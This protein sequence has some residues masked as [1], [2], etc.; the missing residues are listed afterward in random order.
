VGGGIDGVYN[1]LTGQRANYRDAFDGCTDQQ[2]SYTSHNRGLLARLWGEAKSWGKA[3]GSQHHVSAAFDTASG[4]LTSPTEKNH[5]VNA[6]TAYVKNHI[7]PTGKLIYLVGTSRGGCVMYNVARKLKA[8]P[9]Y[10]GTPILLQMNDPVCRPGD[11]EG[12]ASSYVTKS[13]PITTDSSYYSFGMNVDAHFSLKAKKSLRIY[14]IV[15]GAEVIDVSG[16]RSWVDESTPTGALN[17][18]KSWSEG[19]QT[20]VW[21]EQTWQYAHHQFFGRTCGDVANIDDPMAN[22]FHSAID[23]FWCSGSATFNPAN[24]TCCPTGQYWSAAT[25]S[26]QTAPTCTSNGYIQPGSDPSYCVECGDQYKKNAA[27][28]AC[29]RIC[30]SCT[31]F[32]GSYSS[33]TTCTREGLCSTSASPQ[34]VARVC[35][36]NL[37]CITGSVEGICGCP[38]AGTVLDIRTNSCIAQPCFDTNKFY[39]DGAQCVDTCKFIPHAP[40]DPALHYDCTLKNCVSGTTISKVFDPYSGQ[41]GT[42][43]VK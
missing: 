11:D 39:Y 32:T 20:G 7:P 26:C 5:I 13:N 36:S 42:Y 21:Y 43:A 4:Y 37:S 34:C 22:R 16:A 3:V 8:D 15:S 18:T 33:T 1:R 29:V 9:A 27:G 31:D 25:N 40:S 35:G 24:Q 6:F 28:T 14:S 38:A 12:I 23:K 17:H 41:C 10:E 30:P 19:G 2:A